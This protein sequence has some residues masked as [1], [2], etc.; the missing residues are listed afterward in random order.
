MLTGRNHMR[1]A[2]TAACLV[3]AVVY[4]FKGDFLFVLAMLAISVSLW[5]GMPQKGAVLFVD[6]RSLG[7][8]QW[9]ERRQNGADIIHCEQGD[10]EV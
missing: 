6:G 10:H 1:I 4:V 3:L 8:V 9:V 5:I 7:L 2:L